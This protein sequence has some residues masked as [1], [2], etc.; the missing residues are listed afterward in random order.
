MVLPKLVSH[1]CHTKFPF[2]KFH[3]HIKRKRPTNYK[4]LLF[5]FWF[6]KEVQPYRYDIHRQMK[7]TD[8]VSWHFFS[9]GNLKMPQLYKTGIW[10]ENWYII[11]SARWKKGTHFFCKWLSPPVSFFGISGFTAFYNEPCTIK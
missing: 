8:T 5:I 1:I 4:T 7:F 9:R 2:P 6:L 3:G 10:N 11:I